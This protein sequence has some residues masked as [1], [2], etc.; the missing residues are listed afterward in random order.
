MIRTRPHTIDSIQDRLSSIKLADPC[1]P[2]IELIGFKSHLYRK[3][4]KSL[5]ELLVKI[6]LDSTIVELNSV[7]EVLG[8][9]LESIPCVRFADTMIRFDTS[10]NSIDTGLS[11]L[12]KLLLKNDDLCNNRR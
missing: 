7:D 12:Q 1:S 2:E 8:R 3:L 4:K 10:E 5:G 6:E 9:D 11:K